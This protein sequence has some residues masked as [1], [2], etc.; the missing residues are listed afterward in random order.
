MRS[1][2]LPSPSLV[3]ITT[4]LLSTYLSLVTAHTVI[5]YPG[6]RGNN[7]VKN[8]TTVQSNGLGG[9]PDNT[10]PYGMQWMYPCEC[11]PVGAGKA[12]SKS[13]D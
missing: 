2:S 4:F 3:A 8:G 1:R 6:Y 7:L 13:S 5:T 10:F 11:P 12:A 9:G